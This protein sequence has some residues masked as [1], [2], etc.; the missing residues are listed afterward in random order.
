MVGSVGLRLI[1]ATYL[2]DSVG[3]CQVCIYALLNAIAQFPIV[4]RLL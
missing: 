1:M 4:D 3:R 2:I